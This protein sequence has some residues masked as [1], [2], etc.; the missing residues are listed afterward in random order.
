MRYTVTARRQ[1]YKSSEQTNSQCLGRDFAS[2]RYNNFLTLLSLCPLWVRVFIFFCVLLP[3]ETEYTRSVFFFK[4]EKFARWA[5]CISPSYDGVGFGL[6]AKPAAFCAKALFGSRTMF[7]KNQVGYQFIYHELCYRV[8][9]LLY[10][11][12]RKDR[13]FSLN[14]KEYKKI[15]EPNQICCW[16]LIVIILKYACIFGWSIE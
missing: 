4:Q 8:N 7:S 6:R 12:I 14:S 1:C 16:N 5:N 10:R 13:I 9:S 2:T 11:K 3:F 15:Q